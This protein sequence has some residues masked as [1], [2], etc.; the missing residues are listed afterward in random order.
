MLAGSPMFLFYLF[1]LF[2]PVAMADTSVKSVRAHG[3]YRVESHADSSGS[4]IRWSR[5]YNA[6][7]IQQLLQAVPEILQGDQGDRLLV[8]VAADKMPFAPTELN[9]AIKRSDSLIQSLLF[10]LPLLNRLSGTGEGQRLRITLDNSGEEPGLYLK[11]LPGAID[12]QRSFMINA[13]GNRVS[14]SVG[15]PGETR[16]NG[17]ALTALTFLEIRSEPCSGQS[18]GDN[19]NILPLSDDELK[20]SLGQD[21]LL[22]TGSGGGGFGGDFKPDHRPGGGGG[23]GAPTENMLMISVPLFLTGYTRKADNHKIRFSPR[24]RQHSVVMQTV[25]PDGLVVR[26]QAFS[27]EQIMGLVTASQS[28]EL[29]RQLAL[30]AVRIQTYGDPVQAL[31]N[32]VLTEPPPGC[33]PGEIPGMISCP[34]GGEGDK[35]KGGSQGKSRSTGGGAAGRCQRLRRRITRVRDRQWFRIRL[36][37][38]W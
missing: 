30:S 19:Q 33:L 6:E 3:F 17:E 16:V 18:S 10:W 25:S 15:N 7:D 23:Q 20:K 13:A 27:L 26:E 1:I 29:A 9:L 8:Q 14:L 36:R 11:N 37:Q 2:I 34:K 32:L 5:D 24:T 31:K 12:L 38:W 28:L 35:T 21:N 4:I 22:L